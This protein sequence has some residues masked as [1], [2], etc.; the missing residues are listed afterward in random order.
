MP[1]SVHRANSLRNRAFLSDDSGCFKRFCAWIS[2]FLPMFRSL[3]RMKFL[4]PEC[5]TLQ[6]LP[7]SS[8]KCAIADRQG[9]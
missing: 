8:E 2:S 6:N 9:D 1:R 7:N 3:F 5:R 4:Q